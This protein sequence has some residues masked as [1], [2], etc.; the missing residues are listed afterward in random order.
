MAELKQFRL[1]DV[2]E[3]LTEAEIVTWQVK[4]G[5]KVT[6]N[7]IIVEIETAKALVELPVPYAGVVAACWCPRAQTV[8]VGHADHRGRRRPRRPGRAGRRGQHVSPAPLRR[9]TAAPTWSRRRPARERAGAGDRRAARRPRTSGRRCWSGYG[10]KLGTTARRPR[11]GGRR[12]PRSAARS[13]PAGPGQ[14]HARRPLRRRRRGSGAAARRGRAG[15][16]AGA[17]AGQGPRRR[18]GRADRDR[19]GRVHHPRRRRRR[20][21]APTPA[22]V[23]PRS[24]SPAPVPAASREERIPIKGVRKRTAAAMVGQR[25]HRAARHR[26]PADRHHRDDAHGRSGC[27]TLPE[28]AGS[29]CRRCCSWPGR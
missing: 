10:V 4:P 7:Q 3:G 24:R 23:R 25:V 5:D 8:D 16:A 27:A 19:P 29:R 1:P 9:S 21:P 2:G 12:R 18:P 20:R 6:V 15:Q 14:A 26:V 28:F 22:A 11:K 13:P 17:Q